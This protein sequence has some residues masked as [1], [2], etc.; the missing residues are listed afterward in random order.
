AGLIPRINALAV[1]SLGIGMARLDS[2]AKKVS[3]DEPWVDPR[4]RRWD[5]ISAGAWLAVHSRV[6]LGRQLLEGV[7]RGTMT[8]DPG[9]VSLLH[10]LYLVRSAEGLNNLLSTKGGYQQDQLVEGAQAMANRIATGLGPALSTKTPARAITQDDTGVRVDAD[11]G[12]SVRAGHVVVAIPP[13][14][15]ATLRYD[16]PLPTDKAQLLDRMPSGSVRKCLAVY[17]DAFWRADG[18]S[19]ETVGA[20]SPIEMT[21]DGSPPSGTP[22]IVMGFV[23]GPHARRLRA[24]TED[25]RRQTVLTDYARRLGPRARNPVHYVEH[26][27]ADEEWSRGGMIAHMPPGVISEYG[28]VLRR[29]VGRI[30]WA[31]TETATVGHGTIDGAVRSGERAALEVL[32]KS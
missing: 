25:A 17:D 20:D 18:L 13:S 9:E 3:L 29:P 5:R 2:M 19:G 8:C 15:A 4:S 1:A 6:P 28:Y 27:W 12:V 26:E 14:L 21:L 10:F 11:G 24:M 23:F 16:P 22:G 32:E 30:H 31:G 7:V